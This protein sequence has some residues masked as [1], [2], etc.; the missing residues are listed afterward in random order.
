MDETVPNDIVREKQRTL[1]NQLATLESRLAQVEETSADA[2]V[3]LERVL[4]LVSNCAAIYDSVS[5]RIRRD[6]NQ[7]WLS[8][9]ELDDD[10]GTACVSKV[11]R[12]EPFTSLHELARRAEQP[13]SVDPSGNLWHVPDAPETTQNASSHATPMAYAPAPNG[14]ENP[15]LNS[16]K[17]RDSHLGPSR[18][19]SGSNKDLLVAGVG[20][21][22]TTSGL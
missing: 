3:N 11:T 7:S 1:R 12:E 17:A 18:R 9:I 5:P 16:E 13:T 15:A 19:V 2:R 4:H 10:L 8:R 21:E 14:S 22:P 6:L 20:F